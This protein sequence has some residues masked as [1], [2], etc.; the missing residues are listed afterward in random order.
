MA[1]LLSP[2]CDQGQDRSGVRIVTGIAY[3][4]NGVFRDCGFFLEKFKLEKLLTKFETALLRLE[5]DI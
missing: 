5:F 4:I 3:I 1:S 2:H